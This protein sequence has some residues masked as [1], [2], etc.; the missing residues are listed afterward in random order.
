MCIESAIMR[1]LEQPM[2]GRC[3]KIKKA[4]LVG[5]FALPSVIIPDLNRLLLIM[6][7]KSE[8]TL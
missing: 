6:T 8:G 4:S 5:S 3:C 7:Y 2:T 1:R